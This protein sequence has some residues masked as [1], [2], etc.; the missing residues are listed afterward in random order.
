[1]KDSKYL[2]I[3]FCRKLVFTAIG[4]ISFLMFFSSV[5]AEDQVA[6]KIEPYI[7]KGEKYP[8]VLLVTNID[9]PSIK[10]QLEKFQAFTDLETDA[11]G[12]PIGIRIVKLHH[13]KNDGTKFS[14]LLLSASTLGLVPIVSNTEFKV[15]YD[16]FVQGDII[17]TFVYQIESTDVSNFWSG[18][19]DNKETKPAEQ[20]FIEETMVRFLNELKTNNEVQSIFKEYWGYFGTNS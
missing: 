9:K 14:S 7:H 2:N 8:P 5:Q 4:L 15:R 3:I 18:P 20:L 19:D 17:S 1:M 6:Q 16:V 13:S 11:I 12:L 10:N